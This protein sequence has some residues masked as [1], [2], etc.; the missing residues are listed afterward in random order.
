MCLQGYT[1][2]HTHITITII[3]R[4]PAVVMSCPLHCSVA[5]ASSSLLTMMV[6]A[7]VA[8][9]LRVGF[10]WLWRRSM[11]NFRWPLRLN[12]IYQGE[13][14]LNQVVSCSFE[15]IVFLFPFSCDKTNFCSSHLCPQSLQEKGFSLVWVIMW[16]RRSFLFLE[17]K[18]QLGHLCGRR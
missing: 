18:L 14:K 15:L 4:N 7:A 10:S 9:R 13:E 2:T 1:H 3:S 11:W 16:R 8:V 6:C 5:R 12:L 17:A